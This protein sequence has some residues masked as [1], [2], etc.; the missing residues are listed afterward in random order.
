M[1]IFLTLP[2]TLETQDLSDDLVA[3][4]ANVLNS[5]IVQ[6]GLAMKQ[7]EAILQRLMDAAESFLSQFNRVITLNEAA[8]DQFRHWLNTLSPALES[9]AKQY[10]PVYKWLRH[11]G[12][13]PYFATSW[14]LAFAVEA[15]VS[16]Y[17]ELVIEG[18]LKDMNDMTSEQKESLEYTTRFMD[19]L[20]Q[21]FFSTMVIHKPS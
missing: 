19:N 10:Q 21:E 13:A 16:Q 9:H 18:T 5:Y 20:F 7:N 6:D 3:L 15:V 14:S 12:E 17:P 11:L 8:P 4:S 1:S 2:S